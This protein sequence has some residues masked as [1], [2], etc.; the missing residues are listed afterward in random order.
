MAGSLWPVPADDAATARTED[1]GDQERSRAIPI[2][3]E[4]QAPLSLAAHRRVAPCQGDSHPHK[5]CRPSWIAERATNGGLWRSVRANRISSWLVAGTFR[6]HL[7]SVNL[8]PGSDMSEP[9]D[10]LLGG[11]VGAHPEGSPTLN[12]E[13]GTGPF[14]SCQ[15]ATRTSVPEKKRPGARTPGQL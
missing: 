6:V 13:R 15:R 5:C 9:P 11:A 8:S 14:L 4:E 3:V 2:M 7:T 12:E 1:A 10:T